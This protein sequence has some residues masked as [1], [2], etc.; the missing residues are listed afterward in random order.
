MY[1]SFD[2][3]T[4]DELRKRNKSR[5]PSKHQLDKLP[6]TDIQ[7]SSDPEKSSVY[8]FPFDPTSSLRKL[9]VTGFKTG[10]SYKVRKMIEAPAEHAYKPVFAEQGASLFEAW[11]LCN[12]FEKVKIPLQDWL[13]GISD[14]TAQ[15]SA[16]RNSGGS[17]G[18]SDLEG[19]QQNVGSEDTVSSR[20]QAILE[21]I[22]KQ[23]DDF[24]LQQSGRSRLMNTCPDHSSPI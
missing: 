9:E 17:G 21:H 20:Q 14:K 3:A 18:S 1:F 19:S 23:R 2:I 8:L 7:V 10:V 5:D 13:G 6:Y 12:V 24:L 15:L 4:Y 16:A 11:N 22:Q